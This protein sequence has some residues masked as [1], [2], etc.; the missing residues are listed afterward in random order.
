MGPNLYLST[1]WMFMLL[2]IAHCK[3]TLCQ[4]RQRFTPKY[5]LKCSTFKFLLTIICCLLCPIVNGDGEIFQGNIPHNITA[6]QLEMVLKT[7]WSLHHKESVLIKTRL[8]SWI[9][10]MGPLK[11]LT[12][13]WQKVKDNLGNIPLCQEIFIVHICI[14][15]QTGHCPL[16]FGS[17]NAMY[18]SV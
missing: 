8:S 1:F 18:E 2:I 17:Y 5:W 4:S 11:G 12:K 15:T 6:D 7:S 16:V 3:G 14:F 9:L 13:D 10:F